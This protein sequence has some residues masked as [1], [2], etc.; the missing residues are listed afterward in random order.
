MKEMDDRITQRTAEEQ[1]R[2]AELAEEEE[3]SCLLYTSCGSE[4]EAAAGGVGDNR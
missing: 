1:Q 2:L 3:Q 4:R